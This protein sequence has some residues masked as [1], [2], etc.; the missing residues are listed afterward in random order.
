MTVR[1]MRFTKLLLGLGLAAAAGGADLKKM[2]DDFVSNMQQI[3]ANLPVL[4]EQASQILPTLVSQVVDNLPAFL[5]AIQ[6]AFLQVVGI[7]PTI[8]P[9]LID[10]ATM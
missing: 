9:A 2:A 10:T 4:A 6:Q 8:M 5:S 7:L 1:I 3:T